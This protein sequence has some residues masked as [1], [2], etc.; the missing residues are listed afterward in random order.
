MELVLRKVAQNGAL[1]NPFDQDIK[2]W[3]QSLVI[4]GDFTT[5]TLTHF[6]LDR[7]MAKS[8]CESLIEQSRVI[9]QVTNT[10]DSLFHFLQA[11]A[12]SS[13]LSED[14]KYCKHAENKLNK[15]VEL[16]CFPVESR[17]QKRSQA[18]KI[19]NI[20]FNE[21][22]REHSDDFPVMQPGISRDTSKTT[23][24]KKHR[25]SAPSAPEVKVALPFAMDYRTYNLANHSPRYNDSMSGCIAKSVEKVMSQMKMHFFNPKNPFSILEFLAVSK[26]P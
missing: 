2:Y 10:P 13:K 1:D 26:M 20:L 16:D 24:R 15:R 9:E 12:I 5:Q 25:A 14:G 4:K 6:R 19:E 3:T 21:K 8:I 17:E 18:A 7:P 22:L 11:D 23:R